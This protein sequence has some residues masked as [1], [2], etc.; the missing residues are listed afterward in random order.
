MKKY[1]LSYICVGLSLAILVV[2]FAL[3]REQQAL[4]DKL[5]RLH[6]VANSDSD[7]DQAVKLAVRDVILEAAEPLVDS[8]NPVDDLSRHLTDLE[9]VANEKLAGLGS[10]NQATVTLERE[11]FPTRAY[12]TFTLPAGAYTS[13]RVTIGAGDG[14][15]WWCVVYPALC[16]PATVEEL[17]VAA[18]D[19]G[20][21]QGEIALI[22][23]QEV[24][25]QLKFK[26][27]EW[28]E[29]IGETLGF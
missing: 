10:E 14:H 15:N 26:S 19:A 24:G 29:E 23:G 25:Y 18:L 1:N 17:E 4:A 16:L 20:L 2:G 13:L 21:S 3:T 5:V 6:V 7:Y 9:Q 22:T 12:D 11:L 28:L 8:G 27:L